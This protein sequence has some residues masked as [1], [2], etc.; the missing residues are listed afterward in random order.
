MAYVARSG[1]VD[2]SAFAGADVPRHPVSPEIRVEST[3][4]V[5]SVFLVEFRG[6]PLGLT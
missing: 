2:L 4:A 1:G 3:E 5:G 6:A